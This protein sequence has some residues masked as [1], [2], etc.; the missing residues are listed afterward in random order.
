MCLGGLC[1]VRPGVGVGSTGR[2]VAIG[3]EVEIM[4]GAGVIGVKREEGP[5]AGEVGSEKAVKGIVGGSKGEAGS[6]GKH[7]RLGSGREGF[8]SLT[9]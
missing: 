2:G 6:N 9:G 7:G 4:D 1:G 3:A 5:C 8:L